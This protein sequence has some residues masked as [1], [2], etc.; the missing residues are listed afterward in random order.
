[1][2][3]VCRGPDSLKM[4]YRLVFLF[5][6]TKAKAAQRLVRI[7]FMRHARQDILSAKRKGPPTHALSMRPGSYRVTPHTNQR[8]FR[9]FA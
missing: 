7:F 8:G 2:V 4:G 5:L 1:M 3:D 6:S 9:V